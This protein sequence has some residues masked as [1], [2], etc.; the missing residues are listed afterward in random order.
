MVIC[1]SS[2]FTQL[3]MII[4]TTADVR[5]HTSEPGFGDLWRFVLRRDGYQAFSVRSA[6][7]VDGYRV[8]YDPDVRQLICIGP[9]DVPTQ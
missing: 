7:L 1:Q 8:P 4:E 3:W 9:S 6:L 2:E 5:V